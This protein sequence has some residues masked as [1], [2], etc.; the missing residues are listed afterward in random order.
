MSMPFIDGVGGDIYTGVGQRSDEHGDVLDNNRRQSD[1]TIDA[2]LYDGLQDAPYLA[3]VR[4][5][6]LISTDT[7]KLTAQLRLFADTGMSV[8]TQYDATLDQVTSNLTVSDSMT[9]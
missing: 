4:S 8:G 3:A 2:D 5:N 7:G 1:T 6:E 9:A